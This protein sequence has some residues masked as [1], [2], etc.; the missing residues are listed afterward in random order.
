MEKLIDSNKDI[1]VIYHGNCRDGIASAYIASKVFGENA[2]YIPQVHGKEYIPKNIKD[3]DIYILDFCYSKKDLLYIEKEANR[4]VVIDHHVSTE[5]DIKCLKEYVFDNKHSGAYLTHKYFFPNQK[6][7]TLFKYI[8]DYDTFNNKL[9]FTKEITTYI[10]KDDLD[11]LTFR[12]LKE[13]EKELDEWK[14]KY[15]TT[16]EQLIGVKA[17]LEETLTRISILSDLHIDPKNDLI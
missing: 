17:E 7:P 5:K 14:L 10:Y 11:E 9:P 12:R 2:S 3:K 13:L 8:S 15:Y 1:L 4:L 16:L 6:V